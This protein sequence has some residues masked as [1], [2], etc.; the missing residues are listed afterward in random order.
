MSTNKKKSTSPNAKPL[1]IYAAVGQI[2]AGQTLHNEL[3]GF[4]LRFGLIENRNFDITF[5][6]KLGLRDESRTPTPAANAG[7]LLFIT[8]QHDIS[9]EPAS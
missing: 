2:N 4:T 5:P 1:N 3:R 8:F 6:K 7:F 9:S